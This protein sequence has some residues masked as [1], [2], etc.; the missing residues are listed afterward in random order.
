MRTKQFH[1]ARKGAR[2]RPRKTPDVGQAVIGHFLMQY[3]NVREAIQRV[4]RQALREFDRDNGGVVEK[5][6]VEESHL[7]AKVRRSDERLANLR[8]QLARTKEF[9]RVAPGPATPFR[10][11]SLK[12]RLLSAAAM[13]MSIVVVGM[14]AANVYANLTSAGLPVFIESPA[15]CWLLAAIVPCAAF[16]LHA[17]YDFLQSERS[18]RAFDRLLLGC[19]ALAVAGWSWCFASEF[20]GVTATLSLVLDENNQAG[21]VFVWLQLSSEILLGASLARIADQTSFKYAPAEYRLTPEYQE[22]ER[23]LSRQEELHVQLQSEV[24]AL[25]GRK[26][27]VEAAREAAVNLAVAEFVARRTRFDAYQSDAH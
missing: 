9:D 11:W 23:A 5:L 6:L 1:K 22:I 27:E 14:G 7:N 16:V 2:G 19:T 25:I 4:E 18:R 26:S 17:T 15:L 21:S 12:D 3:P 20:A 13:V 10:Q 8:S 24:A